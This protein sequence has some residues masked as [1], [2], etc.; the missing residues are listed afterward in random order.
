MEHALRLERN[1][2][3][4]VKGMIPAAEVA[5]SLLALER[6]IHKS[7]ILMSAIVGCSIDDTE[8]YIENLSTG[9]LYEDVIVKFLFGS[10]ERL[11]QFIA[12][13]R[14]LTGVDQIMDNGGKKSRIFAAVIGVL[15]LSGGTYLAGKMRTPTTSIEA[16]N[17]VIIQIGAAELQ[18]STDELS[19]IITTAVDSM[20]KRAKKDLAESAAAAVR[21]ARTRE[22]ASISL[23]KEKIIQIDEAA[24][25]SFPVNIE[26]D[27]PEE[28]DRPYSGVTILLRAVDLDSVQKGWAAIIP[29]ISA[30][31][32]R[33]IVAAKDSPDL[34]GRKSIEGD[35]VVTYKMKGANM[36][37]VQ[38]SL[39]RYDK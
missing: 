23:D 39:L 35:V 19:T 18:M 30:R 29:E 32:C 26:P 8:V 22:G 5:R 33:L 37:P 36:I 21:P 15:L 20:G 12:E 27:K 31:R 10:Q 25:R 13:L 34:F 9:S 14:T 11:D 24:V 1:V 3:Y 38:Y 7:P 4:N 6:V 28:L 16:N 2:G 17:N